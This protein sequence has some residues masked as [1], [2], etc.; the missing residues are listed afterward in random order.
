MAKV[1][2]EFPTV[3]MADIFASSFPTGEFSQMMN[4]IAE[5]I[6]DFDQRLEESM[7]MAVSL[8][9]HEQGN[10]RIELQGYLTDS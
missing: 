1:I 4:A 8:D 2:I 7:D 10:H 3:E 9:R 6:D 5:E